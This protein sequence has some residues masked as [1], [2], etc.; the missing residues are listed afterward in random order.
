M[1]SVRKHFHHVKQVQNI[2]FTT[3]SLPLLEGESV[4][5]VEESWDL[6]VPSLTSITVIVLPD[7][8]KALP[9]VSTIE[10]LFPGMQHRLFIQQSRQIYCF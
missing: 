4:Q 2:G 6:V 1:I 8:P 3:N 9:P 10:N 5:I 7:T